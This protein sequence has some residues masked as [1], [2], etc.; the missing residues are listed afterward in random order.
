MGQVFFYNAVTIDAEK[1]ALS[2]NLPLTVSQSVSIGILFAL[3]LLSQPY[4]DEL[5]I[6]GGT[7]F[8]LYLMHLL[9]SLC[10]RRK[11]ILKYLTDELDVLISVPNIVY[12]SVFISSSS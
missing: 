2:I 8:S 11:I 4:C 5:Q 7:W 6:I 12:R 10:E 1:N 9:V 3:V